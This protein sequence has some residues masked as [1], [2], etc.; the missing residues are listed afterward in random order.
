M[1]QRFD[2]LDQHSP[3]GIEVYQ[4][5][6]DPEVPACH[7][8]MEAQVFTP[9]SRYFLLQKGV[10]THGT[11]HR[12]P[13]HQYLL[14]EV[15]TG[16]LLPV[17]DEVGVTAP[18]VSPDG[19]YFYYFINESDAGKGRITL[20]RRKL[21][22][23]EP[24]VL[25]VLDSPLRGTPF[26]ASNP[27]TLSTISSDGKK[28]AISCFLGDG[29]HNAASYGLLVFD[30]CNGEPSLILHGP[31]WC[32]M[33]PQYCRSENQEY[34]YDLLIQENHGTQV[35]PNGKV[36]RLG[37]G[38]GADIHVIRDNGQNFRS[39][40]WG[41]TAGERCTGHQCWRGN[42]HWAIG[43]ILQGD[44]ESIQQKCS[45]IGL[46]ESL[47]IPFQD[48]NGRH[49]GTGIRNEITQQFE[50]PHFNHFA[51]DFE[52]NRLIADFRKSWD[53]TCRMSDAL[54]V[55]ELGVPGVG[56]SLDIRYLLSPGSSWQPE[57]HVH[58]FLSPDGRTAFFNSDESG[59]T[60][61]YMIRNL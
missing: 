16:N 56:A 49:E 57:A 39:L 7:V 10:N 17:T 1:I 8:Y 48:H 27:Y 54:Y 35:L 31:S 12:D 29:I 58:P 23:S 20:K 3:A 6:R 33:H 38:N 50:G 53:Y 18:S 28:L 44:E 15:D 52:G 13:R 40:P 24:V 4:L 43:A 9:D 22:G 21:D 47:P 45:E 59:T 32:N 25:T 11:D 5:T 41:R 60:Q 61:A 14:C 2:L 55:M 37:L 51:T 36:A 42:T 46:M 26:H 19:N 30:L 34:K